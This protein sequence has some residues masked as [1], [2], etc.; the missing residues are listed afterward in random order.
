MAGFTPVYQVKGKVYR[1]GEYGDMGSGV[2]MPISSANGYRLP[3]QTEWE[4]A[5]RGGVE[6]RGYKYS[7][8]DD[9]N[10]VA[11]YSLNS[12]GAE[13]ELGSRV[14]KHLFGGGTFPVAQKGRNELDL[15][16]MSGNVWEWCWDSN[17]PNRRVR[18][19]SWNFHANYCTV[20][21]RYDSHSP[22]AR[23]YFIG[24]RLARSLDRVSHPSSKK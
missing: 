15:R 11:W 7:G 24:F 16:D 2:V 14:S 13:V 5:A 6:S 17:G 20:A 23:N 19:G 12:S 4:W 22:G 8:S 1:S 3:S 18:G 21:Y 9:L 10:A